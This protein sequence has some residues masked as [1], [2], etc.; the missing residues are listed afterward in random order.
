MWL[1]VTYVY[2]FYKC[3]KFKTLSLYS[4][5]SI[6]ADMTALGYRCVKDNIN[7]YSKK[8]EVHDYV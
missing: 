8:T 7:F 1:T 6:K 4:N 2:N 5:T 3:P